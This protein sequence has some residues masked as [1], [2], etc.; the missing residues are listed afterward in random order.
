MHIHIYRSRKDT[1]L[2]TAYFAAPDAVPDNGDQEEDEIKDVMSN[3]EVV[4]P[5][6][7]AHSTCSGH[8]WLRYL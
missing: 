3:Q 1:V 5:D 2:A 8:I 7:T 6:D 4:T